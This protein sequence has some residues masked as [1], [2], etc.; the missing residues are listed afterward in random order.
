LEYQDY[1]LNGR[2]IMTPDTQ[3]GWFEGNYLGTLPIETEGQALMIPNVPPDT[4]ERI[5][6]GD[7]SAL[8]LVLQPVG[9][10]EYRGREDRILHIATKIRKS[11]YR[12]VPI[13][14]VVKEVNPPIGSVIPEV[15]RRTSEQLQ[16]YA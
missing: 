11:T 7:E 5:Q 12:Y 15:L 4:A 1:F 10:N 14:T 16:R 13:A 9:E 3:V 6:N 8:N 2:L